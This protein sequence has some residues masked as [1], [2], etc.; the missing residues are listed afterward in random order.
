MAD[1]CGCITVSRCVGA[2]VARRGVGLRQEEG[3]DPIVRSERDEHPRSDLP[4]STW[5]CSDLSARE[6]GF[7]RGLV[8][9]MTGRKLT[10]NV[11]DTAVSQPCNPNMARYFKHGKRLRRPVTRALLLRELGTVIHALKIAISSTAKVLL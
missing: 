10:L 11:F 3:T 7:L 6:G 5:Q 4:L 9:V 2:G 8:G 1:L